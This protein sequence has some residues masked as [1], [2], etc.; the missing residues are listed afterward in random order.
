MGRIFSHS[1]VEISLLQV[2]LLLLYLPILYLLVYLLLVC[3][4][5]KATN[6]I[7]NY[8]HYSLDKIGSFN[9]NGIRE[10]KD[11]KD[12]STPSC[13]GGLVGL[14]DGSCALSAG[15]EGWEGWERWEG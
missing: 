7:V 11:T 5:C 14:R 8:T 15:W 4:Q 2:D 10:H 6:E 3:L 1:R 12:Y 9:R 13:V